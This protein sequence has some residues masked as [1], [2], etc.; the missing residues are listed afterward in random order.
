MNHPGP[1]GSQVFFRSLDQ[2]QQTPE[3]EEFLQ[4]EF[5]Q[6][7]S[8]FPDGVSRRGWMK[9]MGASLALGGL[10]GCRYYPEDIASFVVRPE[11]RVP[12]VPQKFATNIH[13]AGRSLHLLVTSLDGRPIKVDGNPSF[14]LF[15]EA[16]PEHFGDD[17]Q[18]LFASAGSCAITQ[19]CILSLYDPDRLGEVR[20]PGAESGLVGDW[21]AFD[22]FAEAAAAGLAASQGAGLGILYEP[23]GSP[24]FERLLVDVK[25][26]LPKVKLYRYASV[27]DSLSAAAYGELGATAAVNYRLDKAKVLVSLDADLLGGHPQSAL[28][29]RQFACGRNPGPEMSR[30][31]CVESQYTVTGG[32][33]DYRLPLQSSKVTG[34]L[35]AVVAR[36]EALLAGESASVPVDPP[37]SQLDSAA[38]AARAIESIAADLVANRG[39]SLVVAGDHQPAAVHLAVAK[40]N[41][42]LG[43]IGKTVELRRLPEGLAEDEIGSLQDMVAAADSGDLERVLILANNP[44]FTAPSDVPVAAALTKLKTVVYAAESWDE[45]AE[46][47]GGWVVP[48]AHPLE[49]WGDCRGLD[50]TY[51]VAQPQIEPL[52]GGRSPLELVARLTGLP[53]VDPMTIVQETAALVAG[54][55]M[56]SRRWRELLHEGFLPGSQ[57]E[58][59]APPALSSVD[60]LPV[61]TPDEDRVEQDRLEVVLLPSE[62]IYDGRLANNAWLQELPQAMTKL[63]WDNAAVVSPATARQLGLKQ[64]EMVAISH[65]GAE[66]QM[67]VFVLPGT[68]DGS[69]GI[70]YGY[71]RSVVGAVGTGGSGHGAVKRAVGQDVGPLRRASVGPLLTGVTARPTSRPYKLATTQDHFAIDQKGLSEQAKRSLDLV[72]EGTLEEYLAD[73]GFG[74]H[75]PHFPLESM[76]KEPDVA[77]GHAWGMSIDLNKCTGCNACVVACQAENNIPVV[78]KEQVS[79][80]REMH[81]IRID[82]YFAADIENTSDF[83]EPRDPSLVTQPVACVHCETAPC[84]QVCPVAATVHTEEGLNA[85]AY[86]RCIGT[87]YCANN[88]PYKVRRFNYFNYNTDYGYFYGWQDKRNE[89]NRKLQGLVLN[90]EVTV[91]GRGVMEKCTYCV[92]RIQNAKIEARSAGSNRV[93]DGHLKTACQEACPTQAIVFG[94]L[95]DGHSRVSQ[96]HHDPRQY[97]MLADLNIKPRTVYLARVRN[98][99]RALMTERQLHPKRAVHHGDHH[100]DD[101]GHSGHDHDGHD[102]AGAAGNRSVNSLTHSTRRPGDELSQASA[103][104]G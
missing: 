25:K 2:L 80:G 28:Y 101:H 36:V 85:M 62:V 83:R 34:F 74:A 96:M 23:T 97:A 89:A 73:P 19:A 40:L 6:A 3:F 56:D 75:H 51:G 91:R 10:G 17:K 21:S 8:E 88:C 68:A 104:N 46:A 30:F 77:Q 45:T 44:V 35:G 61:W 90:P 66:L 65:Q 22:T 5:P 24:S 16:A 76:W 20:A 52:L 67:P 50:G 58:P 63:V 103:I 69:I 15:S 39:D 72:R 53:V 99:P 9:L 84:E 4:R 79:S 12:G 18:E 43:N 57:F 59:I 92:Q 71:G 47:C 87:R 60:P 29:A 42:R 32:A 70:Q 95:N 1:T 13:W 26:R 93:A 41:E 86:N 54:G 94:D 49:S 7:A 100:D 33:A 48:L 98:V 102:H 55:T 31:Y 14:P 78:G 27:P 38:R 82:R 64:S 81:W 37:Y 11:G